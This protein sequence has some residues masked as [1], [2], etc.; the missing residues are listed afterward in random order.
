MVLVSMLKCLVK[1][2][3]LCNIIYV[4]YVF[5]GYDVDLSGFNLDNQIGSGDVIVGVWKLSLSHTS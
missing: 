4:A 5:G 3:K 1:S 2:E